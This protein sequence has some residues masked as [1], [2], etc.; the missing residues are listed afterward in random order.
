[1][2]QI[3]LLYQL[4]GIDSEIQEK[5][6]LL[7]AVLQAQ[8]ETT[9]LLQARKRVETAVSTLASSQSAKKTLRQEMDTLDRNKKS[10]EQ[11]LYSGNVKN[12]KELSDLQN[13][14]ESLARRRTVL[15]DGMLD[16]M[17]AVDDDEEELAAARSHLKETNRAWQEDQAELKQKKHRLALRLHKLGQER[18]KKVP[19]IEA[20]LLK[21]YD[22]I[23]TRQKGLAVVRLQVDRCS[24]CQLNVPAQQIK[25]VNEGEIIQCHNCSRILVPVR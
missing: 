25:K 6:K 16:L 23:I 2:S 1:M 15:E 4:Q 7:S 14:I 19:L 22:R 5:K 9:A 21:K 18:E 24:G 12:P 3:Q 10:R 8:K 11:R 13:K 17:I 20:A